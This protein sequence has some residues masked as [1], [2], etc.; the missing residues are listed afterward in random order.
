M[1]KETD[2]NPQLDIFSSVTESL[3]GD[4]LKRFNNPSAWHNQ[5]RSHVL[6]R[7]DEKPYQVL[8]SDGL[9]APNASVSLMLGMMILK[10]AYGWSDEVM[11]EN[12][13]FNLLIRSALGLFNLNDPLPACSTYYLLRKRMIEYTRT[14][15]VDLMAQTFEGIT[16]GQMDAFNVKAGSLR[17]DSKLISSNIAFYSRYEIVHHTLVLFL[18]SVDA[19]P[20]SKLTGE[21]REL[22]ADLLPEDA[23]KTVY[24]NAKESIKK[25]MIHMGLLIVRLLRIYR[26]HYFNT[27]EYTLLG[28]VFRD[29]YEMDGPNRV[30]VLDNEKIS[31]ESVQSPDDPDASYR[32]KGK[33]RVKGFSVNVTETISEDKIPNLITQVQVEK[34][35][36][37]DSNFMA[38]AIKKTSDMT[39]QQV[40]RVYADGAYQSPDNDIKGIDIVYT[41]IQGK[42]SLYE[43]TELKK[44]RLQVVDQQTG[45]CFEAQP[46]KPRKGLKS[47]RWTFVNADGKRCTVTREALRTSLKRQELANRTVDELKKRNN[48]ESSIYCL[49]QRL[50]NAKSKYRGLLKQRLWAWS[51][52]LW[53]NLVRIVNYVNLPALSME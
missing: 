48:V 18:K 39:G 23:Q 34:A 31:P 40:E 41:G 44:N 49:G 8:Y 37:A 4:S 42:P 33:Q 52:C 20:Q 3:T 29:Q 13:R 26:K 32:K 12:C 21:Q 50:N 5:F 17:M 43:Y 53:I 35:T 45:A 38:E 7:I 30:L 27:V 1:F 9:G 6:E 46:T 47:N 25:R 22:I 19:A 36:V 11:F 24:H 28:R 15:G 14:K 16:R 51:R 10:E 2:K